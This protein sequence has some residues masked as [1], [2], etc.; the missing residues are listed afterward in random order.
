MLAINIAEI[1][2]TKDIH[3]IIDQVH[4][5]NGYTSVTDTFLLKFFAL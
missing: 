5:V 1:V 3:V 4:I 2:C